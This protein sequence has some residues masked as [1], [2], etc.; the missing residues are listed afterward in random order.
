VGAAEAAA[1]PTQDNAVYA[2]ARLAQQA[3]E[4]ADLLKSEESASTQV[5][6]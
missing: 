4:M 1:A 6:Q 3:Y 2:V 5:R